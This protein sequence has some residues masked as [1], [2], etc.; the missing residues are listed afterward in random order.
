MKKRQIDLPYLGDQEMVHLLGI[1]PALSV[2]Q[3][4]AVAQTAPAFA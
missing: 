1:V 2:V 4:Y 3:T